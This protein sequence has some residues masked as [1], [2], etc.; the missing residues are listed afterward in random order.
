MRDSPTLFPSHCLQP[1]ALTVQGKTGGMGGSWKSACV[2]VCV[3]VCQC[4][5]GRKTQEGF[6]RSRLSHLKQ[7]HPPEQR[8]T[9][10]G[11]PSR[12]HTILFRDSSMSGLSRAKELAANAATTSDSPGVSF[13][14]AL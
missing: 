6:R 1:E 4:A 5:I 10:S 7:N 12:T 9:P 11:K 13:A 14:V 8:L 3:S 2:R